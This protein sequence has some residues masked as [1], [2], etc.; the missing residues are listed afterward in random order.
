MTMVLCFGAWR[1]TRL[2]TGKLLLRPI[3]AAQQFTAAAPA[4]PALDLSNQFLL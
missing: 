2:L 3:Q 4:C 1:M